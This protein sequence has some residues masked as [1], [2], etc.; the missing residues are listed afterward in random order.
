MTLLLF[1]VDLGRRHI[2]SYLTNTSRSGDT[3]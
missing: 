2:E 1:L 3:K